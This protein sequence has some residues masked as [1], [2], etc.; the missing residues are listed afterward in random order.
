MR[1]LAESHRTRP[2]DALLEARMEQLQRQMDPLSA[3]MEQ[4]S[5][6]MEKQ[7]RR[8]DALGKQ[9][10]VLTRHDHAEVS[11]LIEQALRD[12]KAVPSREL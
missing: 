8:T 10:E 5:R 11:G 1:V 4:L 7:G 2:D 6:A 9:Q 3:Q 12:G